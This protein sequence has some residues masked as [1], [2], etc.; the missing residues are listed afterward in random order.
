MTQM[1][2]QQESEGSEKIWQLRRQMKKKMNDEEDSDEEVTHTARHALLADLDLTSSTSW[3]DLEQKVSV[4]V[5]CLDLKSSLVESHT[6]N[7][8]RGFGTY[9][10]RFRIKTILKCTL[11][12]S[13]LPLRYPLHGV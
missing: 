7:L 13:S 12:F 1:C 3:S 11:I 5:I 9:N 4:K 8:H 10:D 6:M 2:V